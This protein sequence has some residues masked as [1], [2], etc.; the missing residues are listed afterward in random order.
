MKIN[1]KTKD[2]NLS[3]NFIEEIRTHNEGI[4]TNNLINLNNSNFDKNFIVPNYTL[5]NEK[6]NNF[7][8]MLK[9]TSRP[10]CFSL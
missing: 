5:K 6:N 4:I 8:Y 3:A 1:K 2:S 9:S 10:K 7:S